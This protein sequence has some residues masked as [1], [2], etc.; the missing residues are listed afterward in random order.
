MD[1]FALFFGRDKTPVIDSG[2]KLVKLHVKVHHK[3][4]TDTI[5]HNDILR[6]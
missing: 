2:Q 3:H 5:C 4:Q 6:I 1:I